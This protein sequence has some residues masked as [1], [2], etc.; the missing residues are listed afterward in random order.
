MKRILGWLQALIRILG[1][2]TTALGLLLL[3][4]L[5]WLL[6]TTGGL[7]LLVGTADQLAGDSF[8]VERVEGRLFGTMQL[9]GLHSRSE[10]A[11]VQIERLH[12]GWTPGWLPAL[13][14][15]VR[16]LQIDG[17][18]VALH[19]TG[20]QETPEA[21]PPA[22]PFDLSLPL[23]VVIAE[24][25]LR[26]LRV[27]RDGEALPGIDRLAFRGWMAGRDI[28]IRELVVEQPDFGD[29]RL[30]AELRTP[31]GA[32]RIDSLRLD[33]P[34]TLRASGVLPLGGDGPLDL[35]L[36]WEDLHWPAGAAGDD[37][38]FASPHGEARLHGALTA[39]TLEG[40]LALA[41]QGD[42]DIG[43]QWRGEEGFTADIAWRDLADPLDPD[44]PLWRSP[45]GS[46]Q[47]SGQPE[48]WQ[49][50]MQTRATVRLTDAE[51]DD[52]ATALPQD[53]E[54][55]L[56]LHATGGLESA[57]LDSLLLETLDGGLSARG[58][59]VW[60]PALSVDLQ[61]G[62]DGLDPGQL[63]ADF[64]G[65]LNGE[66]EVALRLPEAGPDAR[67][68][69]ALRDSQLRGYPLSLELTGRFQET[70]LN[71]QSARLRSGRSTLT[72]SGRVTPPFDLRAAL[73]SPALEELIPGIGGSAELQLQLTGDMPA[74]RARATGEMRGLTAAG[75][76]IDALDLD[77]DVALDGATRA[78]IA[79]R[80]V[81]AEGAA[82]P[83]LD[84]LRVSLD[85][86]IGEHSL[87]LDAQL[88]QGVLALQLDGGADIA[89]QNWQGALSQLALRPTDERLETLRLREAAPLRLS[90]DHSRLESLCLEAGAQSALCVDGELRD[91]D[92]AAR[93]RIERFDFASLNAFLPA[94]MN[95]QGG[96]S[97]DGA[98]RIV[99]GRLRE[100]D[101]G[102]T[103]GEGTLSVPERPELS[104]G[105]GRVEARGV[106][107][108]R[109]ESRLT[110]AVAGGR[111][112]GELALGLDAEQRLD[113]GLRLDLPRIDFLPLF[114]AEV[115]EA[116][117]R[118][119]AEAGIGGTLADPAVN[120]SL[121]L[122][123]GRLHLMTPGLEIADIRAR[124]DSPDGRGLSLEAEAR[125]DQG[126]IR[127]D[128]E[129]E[130]GADPLRAE[131][132]LRGEDFQAANLPEVRAWISPDLEIRIAE[133]VQ[134]SG[135]VDVPRAIIEPQKF[136][137]GDTGEAA[138]ADQII[139][140]AD[141]EAVARGLPV[142]A[143]VTV[144]L[145]DS[146]S[147]SGY[148]L[149]T[150]LGGSI[151]VIEEPNRVTRARGALELID[152]RYDA[153]GQRLSIARGRIVYAGGPITE[154]GLDFEA[155]RTPRQDI[156][157]GIRVR[158][159]IEQPEFQLFSEPPMEQN[160][161]LSWLVLGRAPPEA[162]GDAGEGD[163]MAAAALAL[164]LSGG[165][166]V[167]Q[168]LGGAIGV[169]EISVGTED[170][171]DGSQ[172][173]LTVGKYIGTRLYV[174]YGVSLFQPGH[175]FRMR[176]DVGRGFALQTET[177]VE[178]GGDLLYTLER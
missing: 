119:S 100:L 43:A 139:V 13:R 1:G 107:D 93:Y 26:E 15:H 24:L 132:R 92:I 57:R 127:L 7:R 78:R 14:F 166:W 69:L 163:A 99:D 22:E 174:A 25:E 140:D 89:A 145:G 49:A 36:D 4:A 76:R 10:A 177:G 158:G 52:A 74:L 56:S 171:E 144:A 29:Y 173:Q 131:L 111:L 97:G 19:D 122:D 150:R 115:T 70:V 81:R 104:F 11:D 37:R 46:L 167:A 169:D 116:A 53:L 152:G 178:S 64:P 164:G 67:F 33:G 32:L 9:E 5:G 133:S 118:I 130:L 27:T 35:A 170:G 54:A 143:R 73:D 75:Q 2:S 125:S 66:G 68:R 109:V 134:I 165:D 34:G 87:Q 176:Y 3:F 6:L 55:E 91:D 80:D 128:G 156:R 157:V 42:L 106:G 123:D 98:L 8:S 149:E 129:A 48:D 16:S 153:Y 168:R 137:G 101:A 83:L 44:N 21:E 62:L 20:T 58:D 86:R 172:A 61:L 17:V 31:K 160:A 151:T 59:I 103:L 135:R 102:L 84:S 63:L 113:G 88:P 95:L 50:T 161:Q 126:R 45:T 121:R 120:A 39:P 112:D 12:F 28:A 110:L 51:P 40:S 155:V 23:R 90:A 114:T 71:L 117:G 82:E 124:I 85:G 60:A 47:A 146:V 77:A 65:R 94:G 162:G 147:L 142:N 175:V 159:T 148:G 30:R 136:S 108:D 96:A 18:D 154:P 72:A 141:G 41:P 79:L 105:P 138:H 38:L